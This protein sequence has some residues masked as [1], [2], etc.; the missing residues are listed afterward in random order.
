MKTPLLVAL[1]G[2]ALLTSSVFGQGSL[3]PPG[4]PAPTM[5]SLDQLGAKSD[6]AN[7]KVD[8][9]DAKAE[10]RT[11]ISAA[12]F[13]ISGSGSYYLTGNLSVS[14]GN[15]ITVAANGVTLDLNG[16]TI[17]STAAPA[18]G[19]GI[20]LGAVRDVSIANG[21]IRGAVTNNSGTF[22]GS[23][24]SFGINF[25][26][27]AP[28][29]VLVSR[30]TVSGILVHGIALPDTESNIVEACTVRTAGSRG[31]VA[32]VI[33]Q[34]SALECNGAAILGQVVSDCRGVSITGTGISAIMASNS[35]GTS[36][37]GTGLSAQGTATA[38]FG[39][40][41]SGTGLSAFIAHVCRGISTT[42]ANFSVT[43]NVNSFS[44]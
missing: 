8:A 11:P 14:S 34:S 43:H 21:H 28:S 26:G 9:L 1:S 22:S 33:R 12:P 31:I 18:T 23:G 29:N 20:L 16:F 41:S 24:F 13:T 42:G 27:S 6:A 44:F 2:L 4:P 38:C 19:T 37:S 39:S 36:T 25:G 5:L 15:A 40:S 3:N 30:V 35:W 7:T 17:T 10:K 32:G